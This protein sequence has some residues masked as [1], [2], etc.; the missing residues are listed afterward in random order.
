M[1]SNQELISGNF[2]RIK[3]SDK[4]EYMKNS[5]SGNTVFKFQ[6]QQ[7]TFLVKIIKDNQTKDSIEEKLN[8]LSSNNIKT[9]KLMH[10]EKSVCNNY[11][12]YYYQFLDALSIND[13][14]KTADIYELGKKA[15]EIL[16]RLK[17]SP[18][19]KTWKPFN[20]TRYHNGFLI[21]LN[22][23][24]TDFP[25]IFK[26]LNITKEMLT[27]QLNLLLKSFD[28]IEQKPIHAD[29]G[30]HNLMLTKE[31][32]IYVI[33]IESMELGYDC[34][35]FTH[36]VRFIG[37]KTEKPYYKGIFE[38][39]FPSGIPQYFHNHLKYIAIVNFIRSLHH[40]ELE[41]CPKYKKEKL[42]YFAE[43]FK[44]IFTKQEFCLL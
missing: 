40:R 10:F 24:A 22:Q 28:G 2:P 31:S 34:F 20:L 27:Q 39:L 5:W 11:S 19:P 17:N 12:C 15:G 14:I 16:V 25:Q 4:I 26:E 35:N 38:K 44:D 37:N 3:H 33:D 42:K 13:F 43:L 9:A 7:D 23:V 21:R 36:N 29:F 41:N 8:L 32:Q 6:T 30:M 1:L 18:Y